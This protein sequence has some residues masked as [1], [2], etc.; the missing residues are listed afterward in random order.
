MMSPEYRVRTAQ[1]IL[2][3]IPQEK[4][5]PED[6]TFTINFDL[7]GIDS[8]FFFNENQKEVREE[9]A[10]D[11]EEARTTSLNESKDRKTK[12]YDRLQPEEDTTFFFEWLNTTVPHEQDSDEELPQIF[13]KVEEKG[14]KRQEMFQKANP[15]LGS[16]GSFI[17][18]LSGILGACGPICAHTLG[19]LGSTGSSLGS[20]GAS[21]SGLS[22]PGFSV[23]KNGN[24]SLAGNVDSLAE[25]LGISRADLLSGKYSAQDIL[26][27]LFS[28]FGEG[29]SLIFGFG[30]VECL[31]DTFFDGFLPQTTGSESLPMAA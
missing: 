13:Q 2:E 1:L 10:E 5:N 16:A 23:H 7:D 30:L 26:Y 3:A 18:S 29:I 4:A 24:F 31:I 8:T 20:A 27:Q 12:P 22:G 28:S 25:N 11:A 15:G 19:A 21:F 6:S 17:S 9:K 14:K